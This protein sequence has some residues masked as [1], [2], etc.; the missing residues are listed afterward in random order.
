MLH[1]LVVLLQ[2]TS[3]NLLEITQI[4]ANIVVV[5]VSREKKLEHLDLLVYRAGTQM[6]IKS[7]HYKDVQ[8]QVVLI[9]HQT[10]GLYHIAADSRN[11]NHDKIKASHAAVGG[12]RF[13]SKEFLL[14]D[15]CYCNGR[16]FFEN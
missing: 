9:A 10:P 12:K 3:S 7:G 11:A 1:F 4:G 13:T 16:L 5:A 6:Q 14:V 2:V 8:Y 15:K